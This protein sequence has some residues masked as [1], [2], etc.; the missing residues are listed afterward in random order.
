ML[1]LI[2]FLLALCLLP[3]SA[4]AQVT[5]SIKVE[6]DGSRTLM[7]ALIVPAPADQVWT[8]VA[9]VE[10]WKSWAVPSAW[11]DPAD[12]DAIETAYSLTAKPGDATNI[13]NRFIARLPGRILV[14]RT[15]RVPAGFPH[16]KAYLG[17]T[18]FF[19]IEAINGKQTRIRLSSVNYPAGAAGDA[20]L[21]FFRQ[22]N[23]MSLEA[24]RDRFVHGPVDWPKKLAKAAG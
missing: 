18:S 9:T 21:G 11:S 3:L 8:A 2:A 1:R 4:T 5:E 10:G 14:Y 20:L 6:A 13:V 23:R 16:G 22:G 19:E 15:T 7:H 17:V 12:P 24:L